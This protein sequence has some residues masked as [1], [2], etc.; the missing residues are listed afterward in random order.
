M[1]LFLLRY[2]DLSLDTTKIYMYIEIMTK[3]TNL[4]NKTQH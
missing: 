2:I 3:K 1:K 4:F